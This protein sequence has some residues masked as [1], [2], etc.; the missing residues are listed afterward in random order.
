MMMVDNS[1]NACVVDEKCGVL[2]LEDREDLEA[3]KFWA[4]IS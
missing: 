2:A 1:S 4:M 3:I